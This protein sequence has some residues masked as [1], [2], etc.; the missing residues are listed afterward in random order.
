MEWYC[1]EFI[2]LVVQP[3]MEVLDYLNKLAEI[4]EPGNIKI[5]S[6]SPTWYVVYYYSD[7]E[8]K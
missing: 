7:R 3:K 4:L 2:N 8:V 5:V 6:A 1:K